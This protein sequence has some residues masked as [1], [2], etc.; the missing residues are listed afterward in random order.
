MTIRILPNNLVN[1]IAAGEVIERPASVVKELVENSIDAGATSIEVTLVDGGKS[2]IV[3]SDNGRGIDKDELP[4]AVERHAT[5]K[6]PDDNL[7]NINF[8]GFRGEALPSISSVSRMTIVSR[9]EGAENAWKIEVNGGEKSEIMPAAHPQGTRIEVRDLFYSAPAR[10]K[11]LKTTPSETAQC[12]DILNRIAL[13]NPTISFYL[14][15]ENRKK[16]TLNACQG[17]LFDARL[18]RLADVMGRE[19]SDNSL[20]INAHRENLTITGYVS[21]P[22]LNKSNSLYQYLFV[23]NRPVR[24]KLLLGAIKG[25]YQDVLAHNRYP[26]AALYFDIDPAYV[27]VNVHPAKAEVRFYD[28]ALVRGLLVSAVR[29]ALTLGD[30]RSANNLDLAGFVHDNIPGFGENEVAVLQEHKPGGGNVPAFRPLMSQP[31][32]QTELPELERKVFSVKVDEPC[33]AVSAAG[34]SG[35]VG[36]LG[37]AKAQF[38]DTYIIS[39][40]EDSIVIIDQHASHERI[41]MENL[42]ASLLAENKVATQILLIPEIVDLSLS[43]KTRLIEAAEELQKLGLSVEEFGSTAVIVREIPALLGDCDIKALIRDL[44]G[45]MAEW[46]KGFSLTDKLHTI[47]ATIACHGSVRA[48]RRLNIDEMNRLLRDMERTEHSGQCNHGRPTYVELK[49]KDI[50]KLFERR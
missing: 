18:K 43:E 11:F 14:S 22:T 34:D 7:F 31:R 44:A 9:R 48:G 30:H 23:N 13:A 27:D 20:L 10:L 25:A 36:P 49:L 32:R 35:E 6:L 38:H 40:T 24:D 16:V 2:L 12:V 39:Q 4:V 37:L 50:E 46:G 17:E 21:L 5:S 28:N 45:E 19:F 47:C 8:L 26:M 3:V 15:D 33:P 29:Q 42:K 41:V 1:Q